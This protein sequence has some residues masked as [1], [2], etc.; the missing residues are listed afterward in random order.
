MPVLRWVLYGTAGCH[1]CH[2]A[3]A[4]LREFSARHPGTVEWREVDIA[5]DDKLVELYG[6]RIP[7]LRAEDG[8]A[9]LGWPFDAEKLGMFLRRYGSSR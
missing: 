9:E 3:A 5:G 7:V 1:L 8:E 2:E 4:L 6:F